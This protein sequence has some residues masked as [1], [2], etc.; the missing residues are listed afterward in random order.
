MG[1]DE[2]T[3]KLKFRSFRFVRT[4]D[5]FS[6]FSL[7]ESLQD[8][9]HDVAFQLVK[10]VYTDELVEKQNEDFLLALMEIAK[11]FE[12][13][14]LIEQFERKNETNLSDSNRFSVLT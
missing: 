5:Q 11:R 2:F 14:E 8:I 7:C 13:K 1:V 9:P 12:L 4:F 3:G 6:T 10:W